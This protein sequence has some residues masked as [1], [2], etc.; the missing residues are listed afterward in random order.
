MRIIKLVLLAALLVASCFGTFAMAADLRMPVRTPAA[1]VADDWSSFYVGVEAGYGWGRQRFDNKF[2]AGALDPFDT[3]TTHATPSGTRFFSR[4]FLPDFVVPL[5]TVN[6]RGWLAGAFFGA[7]KQWGSLVLGIEADIDAANI[8]G[9]VNTAVISQQTLDS[10]V[11]VQSPHPL[12]PGAF[13]ENIIVIPGGAPNATVTQTSTID[14]K[15]DALGTLRAK[16]GFAPWR[17]WMVYGT[18]GLAW[19]HTVTTLTATQTVT[20]LVAAMVPPGG[21]PLGVVPFSATSS[22]SA[23]SGQTLLGWSVGVGMDWK[24]TPNVVLGALYLHYEFPKHTLAFGDDDSTSF[25]LPN[26]RQSV[27]VVK[28]RLSYLVPIH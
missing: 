28:A 2:N 9:S 13:T 19:A 25:N 8:K 22:F 7:Q 21:L 3:G 10:A 6:Q 1:V 17:E 27:D 20:G 4:V 23:H 12:A 16:V 14:S 15:I 5:A 11:I 18:G 26:T 24:L